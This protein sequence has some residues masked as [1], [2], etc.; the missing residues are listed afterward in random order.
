MKAEEEE[1]EPRELMAAA[2][3]SDMLHDFG[4]Q[5]PVIHLAHANGFPPQTYSQLA[6]ALT[7]RY[8]V[9][10]LPSRPLWPGSRPESAPT[11]QSLAE[12][13]IEGLESLGLG[14]IAGV[15]HSLG[16]VL[17][18]WVAIQRPDLLRG[19]VLIDP[20][21]LPPSTLWGLRLLRALGLHT[22][23]PLVQGALRRRQ[24]WPDRQACY[25][26]YKGKAL[27]ASWTDKSLRDY[28]EFGTRLRADGQFE[29]VYPPAW[30]A[31]IFATMPADIWH[32]VPRLRTPALVIRGEGSHTFL[33]AAQ[34][35]MRRL[36]P[37][38]SFVVIPGAGHLVPM[39]QPAEVG[40]KIRAFLESVAAA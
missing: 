4:G 23:Q 9:I 7:G 6:A 22:R 34:A 3:Q 25:D 39:E 37:H 14:D 27:F 33:P 11:W 8:H 30:E 38:A 5:G 16:G 1:L 17:T 28:V 32:D 26:Q 15:G 18:L 31:H 2:T 12:D 35:R 21:I 13:L 40:G 20:V 29:L 24:I 19:V 36:L 10:G